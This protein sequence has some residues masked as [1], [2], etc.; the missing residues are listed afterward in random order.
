[1]LNFYWETKAM[2]K[3]LKL[4]SEALFSIIAPWW[5]SHGPLDRRVTYHIIQRN[6]FDNTQWRSNIQICLVSPKICPNLCFERHWA[7]KMQKWRK[8]VLLSDCIRSRCILL[9]ISIK[10]SSNQWS[11]R[12]SNHWI[13]LRKL[14]TRKQL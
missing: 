10:W 4:P 3:L 6:R 2:I 13:I 9:V 14:C 12:S 7:H 1:M 8:N 5:F 11:S